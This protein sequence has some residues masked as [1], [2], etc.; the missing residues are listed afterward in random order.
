M[1]LAEKHGVDRSKVMDLL[2]STIFDCLIYKVRLV[3][4]L[5]KVF[6]SNSSLRD[7]V[8]EFHSET[9]DL[10]GFLWLWV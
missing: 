1:A 3:Q 4:S 6:E 8:S 5:L 10:V 9:T 2:S 7:M